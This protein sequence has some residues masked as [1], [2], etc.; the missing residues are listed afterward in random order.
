MAV[1]PPPA[2]AQL[3][4]LLRALPPAPPRA[5]ACG[6]YRFVAEEAA[7]VRTVTFSACIERVTTSSVNLRL[8]S[9]DSLS[10]SIETDPKLFQGRGGSLLD[11]IRSVE[12]IVHGKTRRLARED[13]EGWPGLERAIPLAAAGDSSLGSKVFEVGT[14][15]LN[16]TGRHRREFEQKTRMLSGVEMTQTA[17]RMVETWTAPDA[18]LLGLVRG[19]AEIESD[20]RLARPVPGVP[21]SGKRRTVYRLEWIGEAEPRRAG[22]RTDR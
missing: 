11:H 14:R 16:A 13:W 19:I 15:S 8:W 6:T 12:E 9:G 18:P 10:A 2:A 3:E 1:F 5:G 4:I 17:T 22:G 20:R 21:E 7:G